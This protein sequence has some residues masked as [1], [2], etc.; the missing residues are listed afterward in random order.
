MVLDAGDK[1]LVG[2][3]WKE[4]NAVSF[5]IY[6]R[7]PNDQGHVMVSDRRFQKM[8]AILKNCWRIAALREKKTSKGIETL[9]VV[10]ILAY[11]SP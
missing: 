3:H 2:W 11:F 8:P 7:E 9:R 10:G 1:S 6:N 4:K 5:R